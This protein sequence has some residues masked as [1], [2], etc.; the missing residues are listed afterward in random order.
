MS[1]NNVTVTPVK[2]VKER[3]SNYLFDFFR[4]NKFNNFC[5]LT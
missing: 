3:R 4:G 2:Q 5:V 1:T